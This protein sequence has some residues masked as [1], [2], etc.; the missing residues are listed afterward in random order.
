MQKHLLITGGTG[1]FGKNFL[2]FCRKKNLFSK[3]I[4]F[5]RDES[6]QFYLKKKYF[7]Y[8]NFSKKLRFFIGDIRDADRLNRAMNG[9]D[10]VIHAAAMK[11][12][13]STEYNPDECVKT[14]ING[15]SNVIE[16]SI[17]NSV[18]KILL[19]S[20]DK[21]VSPVNLY[22]ATKLCAE[23]L[24]LSAN[25]IAGKNSTFSVIRYGNVYASRG[26][27]FEI[28]DKNYVIEITDPNMTR[29]HLL[30]IKAIKDSYFALK[31]MKGSEIFVPKIKSYRLGDV[32]KIFRNKK[33]KII[34]KQKGEKMHES[35]I[36]DDESLNIFENKKFFILSS[37]ST[38][39]GYKKSSIKKNY[40]SSS[41]DYLMNIDEFSKTLDI[42]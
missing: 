6:K 16:G 35:L 17:K 2:E 9:V 7:S 30:P 42:L 41:K 22:G 34:G 40:N 29:F 1:T 8:K 10:C 23:K 31:N 32:M 24:F 28:I 39:K 20:S 18:K 21:A 19:I 27:L 25:S 38:Y 3:I 33:F 12:V 15:T 13:G 5:S 14:N 4:I 37:K 26:S 36:S 11:Q